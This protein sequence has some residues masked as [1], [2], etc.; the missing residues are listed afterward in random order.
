MKAT[1]LIGKNFTS[2]KVLFD[3]N[4]WIYLY[5]KVPEEKYAKVDALLSVK[6]R[7]LIIS[8]Q[9]L[10]EIYNVLVKKKF[11]TRPQ[12]QEIIAQ[13]VAGFDIL[14]VDASKVLKALEINA[15]YQYSYWD[16]L[17]VATAVQSDCSVLYSEDLQPNQLIEDKLRIINPFI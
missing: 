15:R 6:I 13:L 9:I 14:E 4:L 10:G 8:T 12:A 7:S 2:D 17:L 1:S 16:S 5:G 3:T 11:R